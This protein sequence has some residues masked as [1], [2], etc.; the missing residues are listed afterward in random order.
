MMPSVPTRALI[1]VPHVS[2]FKSQQFL[3]LHAGFVFS[4]LH[5]MLPVFSHF[6]RM[7]D[8]LISVGSTLSSKMRTPPP[9]LSQ[10]LFPIKKNRSDE[11]EI[12]VGA[13]GGVLH[14]VANG[15]PG[16]WR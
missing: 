7:S 4:L 10:E 13:A 16:N 5:L 14:S 12:N 15:G 8:A 1:F 3:V 2:R 9:A 6:T 11:T